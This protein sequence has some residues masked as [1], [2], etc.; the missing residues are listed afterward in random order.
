MRIIG[1]SVDRREAASPSCVGVAT[2]CRLMKVLMRDPGE[3]AQQHHH[4]DIDG[5]ADE[6]APSG[7][8]RR[9]LHQHVDVPYREHADE[10]EDGEDEAVRRRSTGS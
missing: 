10:G 9:G 8:S 7:P 2:S 6:R 1:S 4:R 5:L 3:V